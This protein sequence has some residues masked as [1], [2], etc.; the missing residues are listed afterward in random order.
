MSAVAL[1][2]S[3]FIWYIKC[4]AIY[5]IFMKGLIIFI[6]LFSFMACGEY[7]PEHRGGCPNQL[8]NSVWQTVVSGYWLG[9]IMS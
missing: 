1:T 8:D 2:Y 4:N 3:N 9:T 5:T 7:I 6:I